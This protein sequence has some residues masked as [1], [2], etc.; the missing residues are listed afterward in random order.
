MATTGYIVIRYTAPH[1]APGVNQ[2][3]HEAG[4]KLLVPREAE[5]RAAGGTRWWV[6]QD[7]FGNSPRIQWTLEFET[8]EQAIAWYVQPKTLATTDAWLKLGTLD[9]EVSVH[10]L[11]LEG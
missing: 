10:K 2:A 9:Y 4:S 3:W 8:V 6:T 5:W 1:G 7:V 11:S